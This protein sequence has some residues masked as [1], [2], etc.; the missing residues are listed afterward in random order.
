MPLLRTEKMWGKLFLT[1]TKSTHLFGLCRIQ[2]NLGELHQIFINQSSGDSNGSCCPSTP[3]Q[4]RVPGVQL[5][6]RWLFSPSTP[7]TNKGLGIHVLCLL[8]GIYKLS[9]LL[10][11]STLWGTWICPFRRSQQQFTPMNNRPGEQEVRKTPAQRDSKSC[12]HTS[13]DWK[14][15]VASLRWASLGI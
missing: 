14:L 13:E 15:F 10:F 7:L 3:T 4:A 2:M 11:Q 8:S 1:H 12:M 9:S 6:I 5:L